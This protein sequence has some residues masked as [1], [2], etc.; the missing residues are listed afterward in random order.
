VVSRYCSSTPCLLASLAIAALTGPSIIPGPLPLL[1]ALASNEPVDINLKG[2]DPNVPLNKI[3]PAS[4][5]PNTM[6]IYD[7]A[8]KDTRSLTWV[9]YDGVT[10]KWTNYFLHLQPFEKQCSFGAGCSNQF[11]LPSP[12]ITLVVNNKEHRIAMTDP[13]TNGYYI[14]LET[15]KAIASFPLNTLGV[16]IPGIKMSQYR[17]GAKNAMAIASIL[18]TSVELRDPSAPVTSSKEK[19]LKDAE[20]LHLRGLITDKELKDSRIKIISD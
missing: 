18:N 11:P 6:V 20:E 15:R 8:S 10:S 2:I 4:S 16:L 17:I 1:S 12:T 3:L 5:P 7:R 14:P 19:R 13:A 9:K